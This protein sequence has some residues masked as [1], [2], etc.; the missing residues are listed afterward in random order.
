LL[1]LFLCLINELFLSFRGTTACRVFFP[2]RSFHTVE[3][4]R[5]SIVKLAF[6]RSFG[7]RVSPSLLRTALFSLR[8]LDLEDPRHLLSRKRGSVMRGVAIPRLFF[9]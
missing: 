8:F 7:V 2:K 9:F 4:G 1:L 5:S 3:L 6:L